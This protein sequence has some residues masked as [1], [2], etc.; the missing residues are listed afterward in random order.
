V[1]KGFASEII[2]VFHKVCLLWF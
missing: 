2:L 1:A